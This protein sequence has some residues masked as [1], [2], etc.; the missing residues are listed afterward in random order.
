[1]G[2]SLVLVR[3]NP[4]VVRNDPTSYSRAY[5]RGQASE[6]R[7]SGK[8]VRQPVVTNGGVPGC[9]HGVVADDE[10]RC[11]SPAAPAHRMPILYAS[12]THNS[13]SEARGA[14]ALGLSVSA[15]TIASPSNQSPDRPAFA[16]APLGYG[17]GVRPGLPTL[18]FPMVGGL[19]PF[20]VVTPNVEG[21]IRL[22]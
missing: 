9:L 21:R 2:S 1:M 16:R 22:T 18:E 7:L 8:Q 10:P 19:P 20:E 6:P 13:S 17:G 12:S 15:W 3:R 5:R 14:E 11:P 4:G